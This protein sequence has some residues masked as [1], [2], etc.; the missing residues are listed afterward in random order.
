MLNLNSNIVLLYGDI[1]LWSSIFDIILQL[2]KCKLLP[3]ILV[4]VIF[5]NSINAIILI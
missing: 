4:K 3:T 5:L 1:N 2:D